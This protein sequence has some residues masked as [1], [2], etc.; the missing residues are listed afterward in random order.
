MSKPTVYVDANI[1]SML[2]YRGANPHAL[3]WQLTTREWW[4]D[5]RPFF[6]LS[7]SQTVEDELA[8]G[9]Y[10]G[11][12]R[13]LAEVRRL[14]YLPVAAAVQE[15]FAN[16]LAAH[17]IPAAVPGD[18]FHLAF[19]TVYRVDYLLSWNRAH[20]VSDETQAKLARFRAAFGLRTPLVV[21]PD[22]IPKVALGETIRRR[23]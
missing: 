7:A 14:P 20:L 16:L 8:A 23:D 15:V 6:R 1:I 13:T 10:P 12:E 21:S 19:A 2:H 4:Q 11:Q 18:A 3:K 5:E 17:I 22:S 9:D